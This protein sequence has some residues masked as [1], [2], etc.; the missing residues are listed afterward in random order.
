M[1]ETPWFSS[2]TSQT[3]TVYVVLTTSLATT[4]LL[5]WCV[6]RTLRVR[7]VLMQPPLP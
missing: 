1:S 3:S 4:V 6:Y 2:R 5:M 7:T